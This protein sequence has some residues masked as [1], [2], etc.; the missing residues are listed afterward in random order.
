MADV[1]LAIR[2]EWLDLILR[3]KKTAEFRRAMP[4]N[5]N[6][7]D[8]VYFYKQRRISGVATVKEVHYGASGQLASDFAHMGCIDRNEA[9]RY[10]YGGKRPGVIE[11]ED[12]YYDSFPWEGPV[13]QNFVYYVRQDIGTE[14]PCSEVG[15]EASCEH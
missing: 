2:P 3:G 6:P 14:I 1:V 12:A 5:L 13:V 9:Q 8:R 11:L 10:L 4:K 7:G 15:K